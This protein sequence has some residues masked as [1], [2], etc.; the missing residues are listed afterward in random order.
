MI[1]F[2]PDDVGEGDILDFK[3]KRYLIEKGNTGKKVI[4]LIEKCKEII[5]YLILMPPHLRGF[6][7]FR[8]YC[9]K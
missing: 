3:I 5:K 4:G 2:S 6:F 7:Y 1:E 9:L 8:D